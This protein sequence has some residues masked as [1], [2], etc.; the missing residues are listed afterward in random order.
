MIHVTDDRGRLVLLADDHM[1]PEPAS[2]VLTHGEF[3]NAWQRYFSDGLWHR[4]KA[5]KTWGQLTRERNV[6]LVYDAAKRTS[7]ALGC[8]ACEISG[9]VCHNHKQEV[10]A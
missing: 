2:V 4:G 7:M 5:T 10:S 8:R 1:E 3:G 6:V 9:V